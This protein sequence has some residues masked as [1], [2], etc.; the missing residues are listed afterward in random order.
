MVRTTV[1]NV[2]LS[3]FRSERK[4]CLHENLTSLI[5]AFELVK[6]PKIIYYIGRFPFAIYFAHLSCYLRD[7]WIKMDAFVIEVKYA[8]NLQ[9]NS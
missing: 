5:V 8:R 2:L 3:V 7:I 9:D 6:D 4:F 1:R